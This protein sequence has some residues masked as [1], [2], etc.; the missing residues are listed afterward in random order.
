METM[1][2]FKQIY[3]AAM[4]AGAAAAEAVTPRPMVVSGGSQQ[5]AKAW[6]VSEGVCGFAWVIIKG[7]T[8]FGK[9]AKKEGLA[10]AAYPT[11]LQFWVGDYGQSMQRKEAHAYAMAKVLNVHGIAAYAGSRMD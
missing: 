2:K 5:G 10:H 6:Y 7:N 11:G 3:D 4:A 9:W 8:A 1:N